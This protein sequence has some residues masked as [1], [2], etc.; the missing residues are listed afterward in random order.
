MGIIAKRRMVASG[1]RGRSALWV[2]REGLASKMLLVDKRVQRHRG[3]VPALIGR[4]HTVPQD[5][6]NRY[7]TIEEWSG[8]WGRGTTLRRPSPLFIFACWTRRARRRR[9]NYC[10]GRGIRFTANNDSRPSRARLAN[11]RHRRVG[12]N[13]N[14]SSGDHA[15][16]AR[17]LA[18]DTAA[19]RETELVKEMR[20]KLRLCVHLLQVEQDAGRVLVGSAVF[21][22]DHFPET[23][24]EAAKY[25]THHDGSNDDGGRQRDR[26]VR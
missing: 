16:L 1:S 21:L 2:R 17:G 26:Q 9:W 22:Q 5:V 7:R 25:E 23:D 3:I 20:V 13:R 10:C 18:T 8:R 19:P 4:P 11:R 6:V 14:S 24:K 15:P 12:R